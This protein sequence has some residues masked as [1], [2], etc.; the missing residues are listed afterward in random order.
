MQM[1][2]F[3]N[4][5][6]NIVFNVL[7]WISFAASAGSFDDFFKAAELDNESA[8]VQLAL[9]GFDLNTRNER[10][11]HALHVALRE[12]SIKVVNFLL[13]QR[14]VKV[15]SRNA[16]G[17]SPLM[18]AAIRGQ[19]ASAKRLIERGAEVNKTGWT[20]L[21]Y[22]ASRTEPDGVDMVRLML[23]HHA[24]IDAESPNKSTPLMMA[25]HYGY[26]DVV[27]LLLEEGADPS[28]R[29]EQGLTAVDFARRARRDDMAE[30]LA[31]ALRARQTKGR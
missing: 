25:A 20:P 19:L 18:I 31:A 9:R 16:Q 2:H 24:Y 3:K 11:D 13:S 29:N 17:E 28:L 12:D 4:L 7:F 30:L 14:T 1:Y 6:K 8:M 27:R 26:S 5:K 15:E 21:H 22:A 10:G 23:Q